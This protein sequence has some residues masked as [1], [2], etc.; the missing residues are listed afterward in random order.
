MQKRMILAVFLSALLSF[1]ILSGVAKA[2]T[3]TMTGVEGGSTYPENLIGQIN[4]TTDPSGQLQ[5]GYCVEKSVYS[6]LGTPYAYELRNITGYYGGQT[7]YGLI[8]ADLI[9]KQYHDGAVSNAEKNKL[10]H[11]IWNA[12]TDYKKPNAYTFTYT[13]GILESLFDIAYVENAYA[14]CQEWGQD[15]IVYRPV[16][17]PASLMLLGLGLVGMGVA[18]RRKFVIQVD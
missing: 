13:E 15:L 16:S 7:N 3:F 18:A 2:T 1:G 5:W 14:N 11:D 4:L 8:A 10:Q 6:Y 9:W 12:W 17:E